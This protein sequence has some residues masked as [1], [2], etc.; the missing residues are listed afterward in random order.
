MSG[1][2]NRIT[3]LVIMILGYSNTK[4]NREEECFSIRGLWRSLISTAKTAEIRSPKDKN[5]FA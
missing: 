3:R 2:V 4:K 1:D 5:G